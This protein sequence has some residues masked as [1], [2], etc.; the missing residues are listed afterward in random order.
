MKPL[1]LVC[2]AHHFKLIN[3]RGDGDGG[4]LNKFVLIAHCRP[5][6]S[7]RVSLSDAPPETTS[8]SDEHKFK[9]KRKS[10]KIS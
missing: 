4:T 9:P 2:A 1:T 6:L 10:K 7:A 5:S 3:K 8:Q